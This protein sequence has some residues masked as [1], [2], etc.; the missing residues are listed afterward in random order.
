VHGLGQD[1]EDEE[2]G[3]GRVWLTPAAPID[4]MA[5]RVRTQNFALTRSRPAPAP[6]ALTGPT[7]AVRPSHFGG[8]A[9][10]STSLIH[11]PA[12]AA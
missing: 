12:A 7:V 9:S 4:A 1:D 8:G 10:G 11:A 6:K 2:V 3:D 5:P